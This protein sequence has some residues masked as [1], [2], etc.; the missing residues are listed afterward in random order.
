MM[1]YI[2]EKC[3]MVYKADFEPTECEACGCTLLRKADDKEIADIIGSMF[4]DGGE[5]ILLKEEGSAKHHR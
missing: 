5:S 1:I 3:R 2:C 4:L